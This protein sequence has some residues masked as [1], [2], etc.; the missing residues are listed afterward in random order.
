M[1]NAE[2]D[3]IDRVFSLVQ[4]HAPE[5]RRDQ[6]KTK[7]SAKGTFI[8]VHLLITATGEQQLRDIHNSLKTYDAVKMVI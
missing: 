2:P 6:L 3:F 5:V 1:G 4:Q 8:S 7:N